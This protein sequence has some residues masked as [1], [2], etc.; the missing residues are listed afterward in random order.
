MCLCRSIVRMGQEISPGGAGVKSI[1]YIPLIC[2]HTVRVQAPWKH[3][4][5]SHGHHTALLPRVVEDSFIPN[6][7]L[8]FPYNKIGYPGMVRLIGFTHHEKL[9]LLHF[10]VFT[11]WKMDSYMIWMRQLCCERK[12]MSYTL[13]HEENL[14]I[15]GFYNAAHHCRF[16]ASFR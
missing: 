5:C 10:P 14:S 7:K 4:I 1:S 16:W 12:F 9:W 6:S 2:P 11:Y 8:L 3:W 13:C 15:L